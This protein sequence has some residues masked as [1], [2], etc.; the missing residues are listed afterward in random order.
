[1]NIVYLK[2]K[3]QNVLKLKYNIYHDDTL[4]TI[5]KK[6]SIS[7]NDDKKINTEEIYLFIKTKVSLSTI[8]I[9]KLLSNNFTRSITYNILE[10]FF[11]NYPNISLDLLSK[12]KEYTYFDLL[13][14]DL[15]IEQ[16]QI[17]SLSIFTDNYMF[18]SNPY[19]CDNLNNSILVNTQNSKL[20][21]DFHHIQDNNIY[22]VLAEDIFNE[23]KTDKEIEY[24]CKTYFPF[25]YEKN[26][27]TLTSLMQQKKMNYLSENFNNTEIIN[28]FVKNSKSIDDLKKG[29]LNL[30]FNIYPKYNINFPLENLFN[31]LH[32]TNLYPFIKYNPGNKIENLFK[33]FSD[34]IS[35]NNR[36]IPF[37][38]KKIILDIKNN[39]GLHANKL[40]IYININSSD[41]LIC[42]IDQK[43]IFTIT[44]N[45]TN[46]LLLKDIHNILFK[47][48]NNLFTII[49]NYLEQF[50]FLI[51]FFD[52]L[53][54]SVT[55][56]N[57]DYTYERV[58][59]SKYKSLINSK[60]VCLS[61]I[62]N[63]LEVE[64]E[65][66]FFNLIFKK[67]SNFS[68]MNADELLIQDLLNKT[69]NIDEISEKLKDTFPEKYENIHQ[70]QTKT[71]QIISDLKIQSDRFDNIKL[72]NIKHPGFKVIGFYDK[73]TKILK[74]TINKINNLSYLHILD[75]YFQFIYNLL[76]N[77]IDETKLKTI[78]NNISV[79][80]EKIKD[81]T[82]IPQIV[83]EDKG[84]LTFIATKN[85]TGDIFD[86]IIIDD[87]DDDDD[88]IDFIWK[89]VP[90]TMITM[91]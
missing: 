80:D 75:S 1:M 76:N 77:L 91:K 39:Y 84:E 49:N 52:S 29:I 7:M 87:D 47:N 90:M 23:M 66:Q 71:M 82:S 25:L 22:L 70:A 8:S 56:L 21:L 3:I 63:I 68:N 41:I 37:L 53:E 12:K 86:D 34:K 46:E 36:K 31:Y 45:L 79:V 17:Q 78:C 9:Y 14:L 16:I 42:E 89:E 74:I 5:K 6:I 62:F 58:I 18:V 51:N 13:Q 54:S 55:I 73:L 61:R 11:K 64:N 43:G 26:I 27:F 20:L 72:R 85:I 24:I 57:I 67:I 19:D 65:E 88:D 83:E 32:V 2:N 35:T 28:E 10:D 33:L 69:L 59:N 44:L 50:G 15:D 38:S 81:L 4:E 40:V 30:T 60:N 48:L